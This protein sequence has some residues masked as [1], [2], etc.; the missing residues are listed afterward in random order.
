MPGEEEKQAFLEAREE[1]ASALRKDSGQ[2]FSVEQLR[3]LLVT[4]LPPAARYLQ[5]DAA[6]LVRCNAHG[7]VRPDLS[8]EGD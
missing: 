6:R 1:L 2:T 5:L 3:P 7:E 8:G 4:S